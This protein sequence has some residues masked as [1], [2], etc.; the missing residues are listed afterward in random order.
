[1]KD[2]KLILSNFYTTVYKMCLYST[3]HLQQLFVLLMFLSSFSFLMM[4]SYLQF[5]LGSKIPF[6]MR[7]SNNKI[8]QLGDTLRNTFN[9]C[10][11]L[12]VL[13]E[14][15]EIH[16]ADGNS[17]IKVN[18][19]FDSYIKHSLDIKR[20]WES[21][22]KVVYTQSDYQSPSFTLFKARIPALVYHQGI[23]LV[24]CEA[25]LEG[26][27]D[28]GRMKIVVKRGIRHGLEV[29]WEKQQV[30][31]SLPYVRTM[32]P[33]PVVDRKRDVILVVFST[34]PTDMD[35]QQMLE[36]QGKPLSDVY[37]VKSYDLGVSWTEP[38]SITHST[39]AKLE[40]FPTLFVP[41]PGHSIQLSCGRIIV[42]GNYFHV[43]KYSRE[44]PHLCS[45]CTN[46][47]NIFYSDDGGVSWH[48]GGSTPY[49]EDL[50]KIPIQPNEVQ[51]VELNNGV[52]CL[53]SRTIDAD[54]PRSQSYSFDG[55]V[56]LTKPLLTSVFEPGYK[57]RNN[58]W[59]RASAGGCAAG[60]VRFPEPNFNPANPKYWMI[61]SNPA[62]KMTR[63]HL[64]VRL[65]QDDCSTWSEPWV[66]H[67]EL[68]GYSDITM[69]EETINNRKYTFFAVLFE[70]GTRSYQEH[71]LFKM[72]NLEAVIKGINEKKN[73]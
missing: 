73:H 34:F 11:L 60:L 57:K 63:K 17:T 42:A 12:G 13:Q 47:C 1:M 21:P 51:A 70:G 30:I 55:G 66:F 69:F 68:A 31:A 27:Q 22:S 28:Y 64:S 45:N 41:G 67:E 58:I 10:P 48:V 18:P 5:D 36:F 15:C 59:Q 35:F 54:H 49:T 32:N 56:T 2:G 25:R 62:D 53:N 14:K 33:S 6:M 8:W 40:P 65:S 19:V 50:Q 7:Y 71:I 16:T 39:I 46:Y 26:S 23:F 72:F 44:Y 24:F 9:N 37:V 3:R 61:L 38:V 52:V 4:F 43:D 20:A 29:D